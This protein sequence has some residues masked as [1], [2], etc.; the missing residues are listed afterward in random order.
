MAVTASSVRS[1]WAIPTSIDDTLLAALITE[2]TAGYRSATGET[3]LTAYAAHLA[4]DRLK[5]TGGAGGRAVTS[6]SHNAASKTLEASAFFTP[7]SATEAW[8]R[9]TP[10][11]AYYWAL[12]Q[13]HPLS[14]LV[15]PRQ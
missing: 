6:A 14:Y 10:A 12:I 5:S 9:G 13:Q 8:F 4:L 3:G 2:A 7:A 11:G 15:T 1:R